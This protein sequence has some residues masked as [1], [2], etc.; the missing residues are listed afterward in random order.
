MKSILDG[1]TIELPCPHCSHKLRER[2]GKLKMQQTLIC[3][4]R[5]NNLKVDASGTKHLEH[6]LSQLG[7]S[8]DRLGK[9]R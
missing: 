8:L 3:P 2:L 6:S 5:R 7:K 9:K 4:R 1:Q